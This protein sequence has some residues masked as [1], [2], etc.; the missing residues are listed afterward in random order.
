M[1][2]KKNIEDNSYSSPPKDLSSSVFYGIR[3]DEEQ[4]NFRD[5]IFNKDNL[6]V[7]AEAPAGTGKTTIAVATAV[8]MCDYNMY[9]GI[10]YVSASTQ[11]DE[12]GF[13]PGGYDEKIIAYISPLYQALN[14]IREKTPVTIDTVVPSYGKNKNKYIVAM[15]PNFLR[16]Q[17]IK[18][19]VVIIDEAQNMTIKQ[20]KTIIT[21][22]DDN[23]KVICIGS[24]RQ[25]DL[26]DRNQ[27]GFAKCIEHFEEKDWAEVCELKNNHR[28]KMSSWADRL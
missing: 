10:V 9:E 13:L 3:V 18:N 2:N 19:A 25:I 5:A 16:G 17:N 22:C 20:L 15:T 14:E 6:I 8:L 21:R 24:C 28:G 4:R 23:C 7:F 11:Q 1:S 26:Q 27:S 12:I